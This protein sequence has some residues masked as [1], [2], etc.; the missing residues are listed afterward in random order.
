MTDRPKILFIGAYNRIDYLSLLANTKDHISLYF[1]FY[2]SPKEEKNEEY[3]KYG[4]AVYWQDFNNVFSLLRSVQPD[5]VVFLYIESYNHVIL[6]L[7][8]MQ[9]GIPTYQLEHGLRADYVVGFDPKTSPKLQYTF[10][11]KAKAFLYVLRHLL[12]KIR[13]RLF[14]LNSIRLLTKEHATFVKDFIRV[15]KKHNFLETGRIIPSSK[16]TADL[17]ISFSRNIYKIHQQEDVLPADKRVFYIGV[18]YFDHLANITASNRTNAILFIDQ[19]LAEQGLLGWDLQYKKTFAEQ[20]A[21][22]CQ[23]LGYRLFVKPH[24][25]QNLAVWRKIGDKY[26]VKLVS[27]EEVTLLTPK[28]RVAMGFYSTYLLPFAALKHTAVITYEN[29]PS[30]KLMVS[31]VF[32]EA[33]VAHAILDI[34]ELKELLP[35]IDKL[36]HQQLP[37]KAKFIEDWLYK[38]DGKSGERLRSVLLSKK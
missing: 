3:K 38:F 9:L 8:C 24:P 31:K 29:H 16:R 17:Y 33:R 12:P 14:L 21:S 18:P 32:T 13:N 25:L 23:Q 30:G 1:L 36:L 2:A 6:N 37:F 20:L 35:A 19:P 28:L 26:N 7:A 22:V 11:Q 10:Y 5:K 27:D 4:H 15:R 34:H